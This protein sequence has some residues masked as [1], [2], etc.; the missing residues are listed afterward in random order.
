MM[1]NLLKTTTLDFFPGL[2]AYEI[3]QLTEDWPISE[4]FMVL[5]HL[6]QKETS[7]PRLA[8]GTRIL[9]LSCFF[10]LEYNRL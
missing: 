8:E 6:G 4:R 3:P 2:Q 7:I 5:F 1:E 9:S 10:L